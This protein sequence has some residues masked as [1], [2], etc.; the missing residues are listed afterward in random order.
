MKKI[1]LFLFILFIMNGNVNAQLTS[2]YD[3]ISALQMAQKLVGFGVNISNVTSN[4]DTI[5]K[6][7]FIASPNGVFGI[8]SGI[9]LT[10]GR[11]VTL[12]TIY[13]VNTTLTQTPNTTG[14]LAFASNTTNN[15][16]DPDL[17]ILSNS[18]TGSITPIKDA[19]ILEF[20]FTTLGDTVK[21]DYV[22]GSEEYT[23]FNCSIND[24]FGFF[25]SGPGI[26]GPF[27]NSA[28][29]IA[30]IP[31]TNIPVAIS[32]INNGVGATATNSCG[33]NTAGNGPY[34]QYYI[35]NVDS[36]NAGTKT[37][38]SYTGFS[39]TLT[40]ISAVIP[41]STYHIKLAIGD[42]SD[43]VYDTGVFIKA[44]S[45][46][47]NIIQIK[48][49]AGLTSSSGSPVIVEGCDS[50]N[51]KITRRIVSGTVYTDTINLQYGGN[52]QNSID[53]ST[54]PTQLIFLP[55]ASDT[56]RNLSFYAFPDGLTEGTEF[57]KIYV[58]S[59]CAQIIT[60]SITIEIKDSLEYNLFNGDT[61]IC[62]GNT[63][64]ITGTMD[65]GMAMQWTPA[66]NVMNSNQF[67]TSITP[68]VPG[69]QKYTIT[70]SFGTCVPVVKSFTITAD[71][72]P[73]ITPISDFEICEG[74]NY[75]INVAVTPA[76]NY[77]IIW[78]PAS[79]LINTNGYNPTFVGTS[80]QNIHL[81]IISPN[82]GCLA[83][84][85][86]LAT[87]WPFQ[88]G[89]I[90]ADTLVCD[91]SPIQLWVS[92]GTGNYQWY[93]TTN[94]SCEFCPNPIATV[95]GSE[96]YYAILIDTHGCSDT[97][98]L[99]VTAQPPFTMQ[100]LNNDTTIYIGESVQL[101]V[102]GAPFYYWNPTNYIS[103][104]QSNDGLAT[105]LTDITYYVTGVSL[106]QGCPQIDSFHITVIEQD[107]FIPSAF[108]PNGDGYNDIFHVTARKLVT[109]QEFKI[110]NR[111][112]QQIFETRDISKGWDGT[113]KGKDQ[114]TGVYYYMIKVA[115][116][117]GKTQFLKGDIILIR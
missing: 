72:V 114:D 81:D 61:A 113:F 42:A 31:N 101:N 59:G 108:T 71:P 70:G 18:A 41:C 111:W 49:N 53:Y 7:K 106:L 67:L 15:N 23:T 102:K 28:K 66:S 29:N 33:V 37:G 109:L 11:T 6:G 16:S 14:G 117:S 20:D 90:K 103:Y 88:A 40:A 110:M 3:T 12:G 58:L 50:A 9:V 104:S 94:L 93:P 21:F 1:A 47:S 68:T 87:V 48:L 5:S 52:A 39:K 105:P 63:V 60:D 116:P 8:D 27:S 89:A 45:F 10:T 74:A 64:N 78:N 91:G 69:S 43:Q 22:F 97:L 19:C 56:E 75:P 84:D 26:T 95:L 98:S 80:N 13:G 76:F 25:L 2:I 65:V 85:D 38:M 73:S 34:T 46:T 62:L 107:V 96:H 35:S 30:L 92:G 36:F 44:G 112:G 99:Y 51:L 83:S 24:V 54:L 82:A 57:L 55:N 32:T 115:T 4:C 79:V 17:V 86:F 100:L 77:N